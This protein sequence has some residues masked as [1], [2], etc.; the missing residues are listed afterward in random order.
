[1][2]L[3]LGLPCGGGMQVLDRLRSIE[4]LRSVPVIVVSG[5]EGAEVRREAFDAGARA[6]VQKPAD[7]N[8]LVDNVLAVL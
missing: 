8:E 1:M 2:L 6:F 4:E 5:Q 3:D 7:E